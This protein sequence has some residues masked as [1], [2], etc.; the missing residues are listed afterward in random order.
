MRHLLKLGA[1]VNQRDPNDISPLESGL[2][3]HE[4]NCIFKTE[5]V[6]PL[7]KLLEEYGVKK[8]IKK[9]VLEDYCKEYLKN[10]DYLS[11]ILNSCEIIE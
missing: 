2:M 4:L 9:T 1:N 10:S 11:N 3:G 8:E 6:E 7:V 5:A